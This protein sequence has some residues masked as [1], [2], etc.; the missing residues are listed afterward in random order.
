MDSPGKPIRYRDE[1]RELLRIMNNQAVA[2]DNED[3]EAEL[4]EHIMA[5]YKV[6]YNRGLR[7][8][9]KEYRTRAFRV[10]LCAF[11]PLTLLQVSQAVYFNTDEHA[12]TGTEQIRHLCYNFIEE[13]TGGNL[14]F[15]HDSARQF[16]ESEDE[17]TELKCHET[18]ADICVNVM[19]N[20]EQRLWKIAGMDPGE[21]ARRY[22]DRRER[23]DI[24]AMLDCVYIS[25]SL[26]R[27]WES[28]AMPMFQ[29]RL[30][31]EAQ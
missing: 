15:C 11:H 14:R 16:L 27:S 12:E 28:L 24:I 4:N 6:L 18:M 2:K 26:P 19:S 22:A 13:G 7:K 17:L 23:D 25:G 10:F 20:Q 9:D 31:P 5:A 1:A 30:T 21:W 3:A 8:K 29:P